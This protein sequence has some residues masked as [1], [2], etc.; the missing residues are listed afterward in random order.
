MQLRAL[1]IETN[2]TVRGYLWQA[3]L[4][5]PSFHNVKAVK[6]LD[7]ALKQ[8]CEGKVYDCVLMSGS[9]DREKTGAFVQKAKE[10]P[11][12]S[13]AAF[14]VVVPMSDQ[15]RE[16][17]AVNIL[18]GSDGFLF[19]PFSVAS[20]RE[21]AAIAMRVKRERARSKKQAA[22]QLVMT[23]VSEILDS[24]TLAMFCGQPTDRYRRELKQATAALPR[25]VGEDTDIY[26]DALSDAFDQAVPRPK[27]EYSGASER[28]KQMLTKKLA[29]RDHRKDQEAEELEARKNLEKP[30]AGEN[31]DS[32]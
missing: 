16:N 5:E 19:S 20:L 2:P 12:G 28:V 32:A 17:I 11:G 6:T 24:L 15:N 29:E 26:Y 23:D 4:A 3:T 25:L 22:L 1:I 18:E 10:S 31:Q 7:Q 30:A 13:E 14:V 8:M 9:I 21:V 27:V